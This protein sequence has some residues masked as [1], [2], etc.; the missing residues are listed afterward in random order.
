VKTTEIGRRAELI[1]A[2]FLEDKGYK[3]R[4]RNW[5]NRFCEIDIIAAKK[6]V[7]YFVEVKFRTSAGQ[8]TGI[9][10][11]TPKKL[12]QMRFAAE[13]WC[14]ENSWDKD[15]RLVGIEVIKEGQ[16]MS[17]SEFLEII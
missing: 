7:I 12:S 17:V 3:V 10:Y 8:G 6:N 16:A 13:F 9:D 14:A 4:E 5:R 2:E 11:I 1:A 15:W